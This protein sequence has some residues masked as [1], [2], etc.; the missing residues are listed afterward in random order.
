MTGTIEQTI[1]EA[2]QEK[3]ALE[4]S[5]GKS[6]SGARVVHPHALFRNHQGGISLDAWQVSGVSSGDLPD[7]RE[8][9]LDSILSAEV[10]TGEFELAE[11]YDPSA[12]RY[13]RGLIAAAA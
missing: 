4:I 11:G 9:K 6:D 10:G 8:F 1:T 12:D 13:K 5:Y 7:W 3:R 2:I